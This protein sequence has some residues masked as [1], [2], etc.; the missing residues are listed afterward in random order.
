M[1]ARFTDEPTNSLGYL[2]RIT[3]RAFSRSLERMTLPLGVS[4]GQWPFLRQL[5]ME[6]GLTQRELSHRAKMREPTTVAA[7]RGLE[8]AGLIRRIPSTEDRRKVHVW[9]TPKALDIREQLLDAVARVNAIA[10]RGIPDEDVA[11]LRRSLL[12]MIDS[13]SKEEMEAEAAVEARRRAATRDRRAS[14]ERSPNR[15][16]TPSRGT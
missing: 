3:F 8:R 9:L 13:L 11:V 14:S 15:R 1:H 12:R 6:E 16:S 7:L 10:L 4:A 2:T 5:W